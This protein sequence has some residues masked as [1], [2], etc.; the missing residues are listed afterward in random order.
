[1]VKKVATVTLWAQVK[2]K[3]GNSDV[4]VK[5]LVT[6]VGSGHLMPT[7]IPGIR[8]M[9]LEVEAKNAK[10]VEVL[11]KKI[12]FE[13]EL[14]GPDGNP[15]M[16]WKAV[17]IGKDTRISPRKSREMI[18]EFTIPERDF[19]S[20]EV[21]SSLYYRRISELAAKAVGIKESPAIEIAGDRIQVFSNGQV[22]KAF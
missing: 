21:R 4:I 5:A 13:I 16:P 12:P 17:R 20:L 2:Q 14:L 19:G 1:M 8:Q 10:G 3:S 6:N 11:A 15:T 22:E 18:L 9:C 7:G